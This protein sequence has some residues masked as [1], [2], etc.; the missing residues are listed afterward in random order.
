[1]QNEQQGRKFFPRFAIRTVR[2][3]RVKIFGNIYKCPDEPDSG[4]RFEGNRYAFGLYWQYPYD[5][6]DTPELLDHVHHWGR[7]AYYKNHDRSDAIERA[8]TRHM[9]QDD[10]KGHRV[11]YWASWFREVSDG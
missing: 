3:G 11:L 9:T 10:D 4:G 5:D 2:N 7:E 8:E 1:M 6:A